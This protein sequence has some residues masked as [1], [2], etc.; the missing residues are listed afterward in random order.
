VKDTEEP[1][2]A[3][4]YEEDRIFHLYDKHELVISEPVHYG[5]WSGLAD[6]MSYQDI[7]VAARRH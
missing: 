4:A 1:E 7:I 3:V 2:A 5:T 6:G